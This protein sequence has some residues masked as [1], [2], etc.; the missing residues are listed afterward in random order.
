[1]SSSTISGVRIG[2]IASAVPEAVRQ[3]TAFNEAFGAEEVR[4]ISSRSGVSQVHVATSD[5]CTSDLCFAAATRL[6]QEMD[7]PAASIDALIFVSQTP[8]YLLPATS[9]SL[10]GRLGLPK[11]CA[12]FDLNLGCSG[13]IYGMWLGAQ[14]ISSGSAGNVLLLVGDTISRVV[15]PLDR[16]VAMLFGDAG[17]ATLLEGD[18]NAPPITFE[19]GTDGSGQNHIMVPAGLF[20]QPRSTSTAERSLRQDQNI[21][22][23]EDLFMDGAAVF[24]F[25]LTAVPGM[26]DAAL[27]TAG[28]IAETPDAFVM[29]QANQFMLQHLAK[30]MRIPPEKAVLAMADY[31]NTSS[32]SIP[33]A[34]THALRQ[35]LQVASLKLLLAGFG[36]G[37]SWGAAA[38]ECGP[39]IMPELVLLEPS[40]TAGCAVTP[41]GEPMRTCGV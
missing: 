41:A 3:N 1:M 32:A 22:A 37:L 39:V 7:R 23:D 21:R 2:G 19:L 11:K 6:L 29:H 34:L 18:A 35:K 30:R 25:T 16:S 38:L 17:T 33:L 14:L 4:K 28:W 10:H 12:A 20:R 31:G 40:T 26:I 9:C 36:V 24:T 8:D 5:I 27:R 13:Y 15:S